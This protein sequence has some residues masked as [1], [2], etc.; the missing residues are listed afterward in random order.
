LL[1]P[2]M[3]VVMKNRGANAIISPTPRRRTF[4]S[5]LVRSLIERTKR[6]L[7]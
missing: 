5:P 4:Q 1:R 2:T 6:G 3:V 7:V